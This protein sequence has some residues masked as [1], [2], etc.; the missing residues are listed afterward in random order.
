MAPFGARRSSRPDAEVLPPL[1]TSTTEIE[2]TSAVTVAIGARDDSFPA[3]SLLRSSILG[4][5]GA[6]PPSRPLPAA[7]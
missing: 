3:E 5:G 1:D 4:A 6:P 7:A 2:V